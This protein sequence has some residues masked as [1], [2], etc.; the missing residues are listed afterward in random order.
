MN[1]SS[2][3]RVF[4]AKHAFDMTTPAGLFKMARDAVV[5]N[6]LNKTEDAASDFKFA[7]T[8]IRNTEK[9]NAQLPDRA[10]MALDGFVG[11][12]RTVT[13]I[14]AH[15]GDGQ[16]D[17]VHIDQALQ[18]LGRKFSNDEKEMMECRIKPSSFMPGV[19]GMID[20]VRLDLKQIQSEFHR[21]IAEKEQNIRRNNQFAGQIP[22]QTQTD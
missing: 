5:T 21:V 6:G 22:R 14:C 2:D 1:D 11:N 15:A 4:M 16:I 8:D 18:D 3:V 10:S 13:D 9:V 12:A 20:V 7:L 19:E 17:R